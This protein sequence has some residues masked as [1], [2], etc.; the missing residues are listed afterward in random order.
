MAAEAGEMEGRMGRDADCDVS[1][2]VG[3]LEVERQS[4]GFGL[5]TFCRR[6]PRLSTGWTAADLMGRTG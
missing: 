6:M 4:L 3:A 1:V 5:A 2:T